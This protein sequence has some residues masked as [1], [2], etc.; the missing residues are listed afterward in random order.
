VSAEIQDPP[1]IPVLADGLFAH[2]NFDADG[3]PT[4]PEGWQTMDPWET[5]I[6]LPNINCEKCILQIVQHMDEHAFNNPGGYSYHQ[7]AHLQITAD[8]TKP[9]STGWPAER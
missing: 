5:D 2:S 3:Q 6:E 4:R 8:P 9:L 1:Q 7:C